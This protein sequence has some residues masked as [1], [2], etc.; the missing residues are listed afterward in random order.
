MFWYSK[1]IFLWLYTIYKCSTP[2]YV[3]LFEF[4]M[5][6]VVCLCRSGPSVMALSLSEVSWPWRQMFPPN[7]LGKVYCCSPL[8]SA[9]AGRCWDCSTISPCWRTPTAMGLVLRCV[10]HSHHTSPRLTCFPE[11]WISLLQLG[12]SSWKQFTALIVFTG[13]EYIAFEYISLIV[14]CFNFQHFR[15]RTQ[16]FAGYQYWRM[17]LISSTTRVNTLPGLLTLSSSKRGLISGGCSARCC[18]E[19]RWCW[20]SSGTTTSSAQTS[21]QNNRLAV[22][23]HTSDSPVTAVALAFKLKLQTMLALS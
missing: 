15:R 20:G 5:V 11:R 17:W 12:S 13:S 21:R 3:V 6:I 19:P 18:G 9:T 22:Q 4:L 10:K 16:A 1:C 23:M 14:V 8:S 2:L 7:N